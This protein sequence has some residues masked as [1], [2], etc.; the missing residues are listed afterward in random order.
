MNNLLNTTKQ[1]FLE[2]KI[3][4]VTKEIPYSDRY[5]RVKGIRKIYFLLDLKT[6]R[7]VKFNKKYLKEL[8]E[9]KKST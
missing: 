7:M 6:N 4:L 1:D 9:V 8:L 5:K 2:G 3:E